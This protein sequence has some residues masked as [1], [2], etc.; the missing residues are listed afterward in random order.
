MWAQRE[1]GCVKRGAGTVV[2]KLHAEGCP[3]CQ[4]PREAGG[5]AGTACPSGSPEGIIP[6]NTLMLDLEPSG[7]RGS[8][9]LLF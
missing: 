9:F 1:G 6:S 4:Q 7:L 8:K 5:R 3:G 2:V